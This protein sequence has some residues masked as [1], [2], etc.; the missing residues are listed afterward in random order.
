MLLNCGVGED[1]WEPLGLHLAVKP[2]HL[3]G[4][5]PWIFI[6]KTDAEAETPI[7]R[8]LMWRTDSLERTLTLG[9]IEGRGRGWQRMR[10]LDGTDSM[11]MSL[12]K[13]QKLVMN[14]EAW[15]AV[16]RR[17]SRVE[18]DW[19]TELN[20]LQSS[21]IYQSLPLKSKQLNQPSLQFE[22]LFSH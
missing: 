3:K 5:Q 19:V 7:L 12:S 4:N 13:L 14:R 11:D 22:L 2:V 20:F 17:V 10:W 9:K 1:S 21:K 8:P 16:V 15:H 6:E 18:H